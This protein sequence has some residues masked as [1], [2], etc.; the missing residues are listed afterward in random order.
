MHIHARTDS[1]S[2]SRQCSGLLS[3]L[4]YVQSYANTHARTHARAREHT[5]AHTHD[6]IS[7]NDDATALDY[8]QMKQWPPS[9]RRP[10]VPGRK[11]FRPSSLAVFLWWRKPACTEERHYD[12]EILTPTP[13][14]THS[15][16]HPHTPTNCYNSKLKMY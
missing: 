3:L 2:T 10:L 11:S 16:T 4:Y 5:H 1:C 12:P 9:T 14:H 6:D 15:D 13:T 8:V 7:V